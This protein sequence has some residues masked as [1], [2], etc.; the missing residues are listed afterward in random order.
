LV[1]EYFKKIS[2]KLLCFRENFWSCEQ[3]G[4]P[5]LK[6]R[7]FFGAFRVAEN[8]A[9]FA[10]KREKKAWADGRDPTPRDMG[11]LMPAVMS[12]C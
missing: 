4:W 2:V 3:S 8:S 9:I 7:D 10:K 11:A 1:A 12:L 6:K 5:L